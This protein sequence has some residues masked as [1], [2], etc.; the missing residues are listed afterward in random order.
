MD[1]GTEFERAF[2][3]ASALA[4]EA[5]YSTI[6]TTRRLIAL[7]AALLRT[8]GLTEPEGNALSII[9]GAGQPLTPGV[10][11][12]RMLQPMSSG[13]VTGVLDS[14]EKRAL[15]ARSS[16]PIDRRSVLVAITPSGR[17][18]LLKFRLPLH[19]LQREIMD[20]LSEEDQELLLR[21]ILKV[22]DRVT[23]LLAGGD[24]VSE[25]TPNAD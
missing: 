11:R 20:C 23:Q 22:Q 3:G 1:L 6:R 16:H 8:Y 24:R 4:T 25:P 19:L 18:L 7:H 9:D 15:V 14:L 17:E 10:I 12:E 13:A 2:P 21:L 5:V